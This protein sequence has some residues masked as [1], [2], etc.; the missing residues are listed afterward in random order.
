MRAVVPS[1]GLSQ[2][3]IRS[4]PDGR[5]PYTLVGLVERT[6]KGTLGMVEECTF[7][8]IVRGFSVL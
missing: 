1:I 7:G 2:A 4:R 5:G 8:F 6:A 3:V